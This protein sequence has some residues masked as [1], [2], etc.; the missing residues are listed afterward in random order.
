MSDIMTSMVKNI[1]GLQEKVTEFE[2]FVAE[3]P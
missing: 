1:E 2:N 3:I